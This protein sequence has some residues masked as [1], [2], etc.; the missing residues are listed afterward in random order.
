MS[1][2]ASL[3]EIALFYHFFGTSIAEEK[4]RFQKDN[5]TSP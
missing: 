1:M 4:N 3:F 5:H 2:P